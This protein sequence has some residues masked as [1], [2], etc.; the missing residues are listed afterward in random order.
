MSLRP[1]LAICIPV[2][3]LTLGCPPPQETAEPGP[4]EEGERASAAQLNGETVLVAEVDAWIKEQLF[5]QATEDGDP[6]KLYELR[7]K[8]L[9]DMIH[10]RLL[11]EE[12]APLGITTD[13][14]LRQETEKRIH[15]G[16]EEAVAFYEENKERMGEVSFEEVKSRIQRHLQQQR[17]QTATEEYLQS[18]RS[19]AT[20]EI[21]LD[22][23]RVEV[24]AKGPSLGPDQAP[25]TIIEFSD[26][27]C[28]YC[29]RAEPVIQQLL[30]RYPTEVRFVFRHFPLDRIHSLARGAAEAAACANEQGRFWEYHRGL[31]AVGAKFDAESLQQRA[32]E[33]E[34]DLEAFRICVEERRFQ[35]DIDADLADGRRAGV[36]GTPAFFVNGIRM[37]GARPLDDFVAIIENELRRSGS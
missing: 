14:L 26:Y 13:E 31:F 11:E 1:T 37:D 29:R 15:V 22:A 7:S 4:Q 19:N 24:A 32:S 21:Y 23:P 6:M 20:I 3:A 10:E 36:S 9:D 18:L 34:L 5:T 2:L 27:Q 8:A 35:A 25:V 17:G 33:A 12:A 16:D 28:P 30:E